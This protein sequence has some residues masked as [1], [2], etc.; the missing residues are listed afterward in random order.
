MDFN[1]NKESRLNEFME[2]PEKSLWKLSLPMM[3]LSGTFWPIESMPE[4]LK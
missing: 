1:Q 4:L 2:N 3:F